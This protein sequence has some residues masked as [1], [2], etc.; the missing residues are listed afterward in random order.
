MPAACT[1]NMRDSAIYAAAIL[2]VLQL[3]GETTAA[4][5]TPALVR[6]ALA[7]ATASGRSDGMA[8]SWTTQVASEPAV[9]Y[10]LRSGHLNQTSTTATSRRYLD[11][12]HHHVLLGGLEPDTTYFY[13]CVDTAS[14][15]SSA[16]YRFRSA[17]DSTAAGEVTFATFGDLGAGNESMATKHALATMRDGLDFVW[18]VG[19]IAYQD[20]YLTSL[21]KYEEVLDLYMQQMQNTTARVPYMVLPGNHEVDCHSVPC[22]FNLKYRDALSNF[23]AYNARFRMPSDESGGVLNMWYSFNYGPAHFISMDSETDYPGAYEGEYDEYH[24]LPSGGFSPRENALLEWLEAD[25]ARAHQ[26]RSVRPWIIVGAHRPM[27]LYEQSAAFREA[28][29]D[30]FFHYGV[31]VF[32]SGHIH[33]YFRTYPMYNGTFVKTYD[34]PGMPVNLVV[35]T[36]G[37]KGG[38]LD[39]LGHVRYPGNLRPSERDRERGQLET[40]RGVKALRDDV[41]RDA[42]DVSNAGSPFVAFHSNEHAV[43]VMHIKGATAAEFRLVSSTTG[44]VID[45]FM[46][47][48]GGAVTQRSGFDVT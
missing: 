21:T 2:L 30:L 29:E 11:T 15:I 40:L 10:G 48:K 4:A 38:P 17:P 31:D 35:G 14:G 34:D 44:K 19:D 20:D 28:V 26:S 18:H 23:T 41:P 43:G 13:R 5:S 25:L 22:L 7:G 37:V 27:Y 36:G 6:I 32:I 46:L 47:T 8:I 16:E 24:V 45:R 39:L 1:A 9:S 12:Y 33:S 3:A 42:G